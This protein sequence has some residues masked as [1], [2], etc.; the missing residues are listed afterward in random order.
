MAIYTYKD[1]SP[2]FGKRVFVDMQTYISGSTTLG[3]DVSIWPM[4]VLRGDVNDIII[5]DRTNVQD[6]SILHVTAPHPGAE[7]GYPL[8]IANDVLIAHKVMLHGCRIEEN[9]MV[10][11]NAVILD[12]AYVP[13]DVVIGANA[14]VP[15]GKKLESGYLY[16]GSPVQKIRKLTDKDLQWTKTLVQHYIDVKTQYLAQ[17]IGE[18]ISKYQ[19]Q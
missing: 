18:D 14:L 10:G 12:N 5:G 4:C 17:N 19:K 3:D 11:M 15:Q 9:V 16:L 6:G 7:N 1:K 2:A 13:K 8:I